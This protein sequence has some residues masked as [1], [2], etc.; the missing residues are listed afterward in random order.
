MGAVGQTAGF[1]SRAFLMVSDMSEK[2]LMRIL[3]MLSLFC[4][5]WGL[6]AGVLLTAFVCDVCAY[7]NTNY[8]FDADGYVKFEKSVSSTVDRTDPHTLTNSPHYS[9]NFDVFTT[10]EIT[11]YRSLSYV[12]IR[13]DTTAYNYGLDSGAPLGA[14]T[15]FEA[16]VGGNVI[17]SG[18]ISY[19]CINTDTMDDYYVYIFFRYWDIGSLSGTQTINL[20]YSRAELYNICIPVSAYKYTE[21]SPGANAIY[22]KYPKSAATLWC[23]NFYIQYGGYWENEMS[24]GFLY[25]TLYPIDIT[26][27]VYVSKVNVSTDLTTYVSETTFTQ[28]SLA[29]NVFESPIYVNVTDV[30]GNHHTAVYDG[31]PPGNKLYG[32]V[33]DPKGEFVVDG[34]YI[35]FQDDAIGTNPYGFYKFASD[36]FGWYWLNASVDGYQNGSHYIDYLEGGMRYDIYLVKN[37]SVNSGTC[38]VAG[39]VYDTD[40]VPVD[41]AYVKIYNST[42]SGYVYSSE[43]GYF[44]FYDLTNTS[45]F[46]S[47]DHADYMKQQ[48]NI[49]LTDLDTAYYYDFFLVGLDE[50]VEGEPTPTPTPGPDDAPVIG[51]IYM[52]FDMMGLGAYMEYIFAFVLIAVMGLGFGYVAN[53][54]SMAI[55]IGSFFGFIIDVAMGW[56]PVYLI[57]VVI[58]GTVYFIVKKLGDR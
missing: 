47:A 27:G 23:A 32:Y 49:N 57:A 42:W 58:C 2:R 50:P 6:V 29:F 15:H 5:V 52:I 4:V 9:Y 44:V 33:Y 54:N 24:V 37:E 35:T 13:M 21:N 36:E 30:W 26:K 46:L 56:L 55:A 28:E 41:G 38:T 43:T 51:G 11:F 40:V 48:K 53:G 8:E 34:V 22:L 19:S 39:M 14:S 7:S 3:Y 20:D 10:N 25:N 16:T 18:L 31:F 45:Y 12:R 1:D 17:G